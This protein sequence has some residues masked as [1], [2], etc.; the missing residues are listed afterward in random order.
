M[1]LLELEVF[2]LANR[3][4]SYP[5]KTG[6]EKV[7]LYLELMFLA[8]L[9]SWL[10]L[11]QMSSQMNKAVEESEIQFSREEDGASEGVA[12]TAKKVESAEVKF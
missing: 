3:T 8:F 10:Y 1:N 11:F 7:D 9:S 6:F 4:S 12:M 2:S 5:D